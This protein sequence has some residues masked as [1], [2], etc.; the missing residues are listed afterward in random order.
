MNTRKAYEE[1]FNVMEKHSDICI[2]DIDSLKH[3]AEIH[4]FENLL[5][6]TYGLEL[7]NG[8]IRSLDWNSIGGYINIGRWGKSHERTISWPDNDKQPVDEELVQ[9][10]FSTGAYIFGDGYPI[11]LFQQFWNEIK[12]FNPDYIDSHNLAM[13]WK[14]SN[15]KD[16]FNSFNSILKKYYVLNKENFN[17]R[18]I[19]KLEE[20][21]QK[22]KEV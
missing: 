6:Y 10:C 22:L 4:M 21:I 18:K 2:F 15:A 8:S 11:V 20:Q 16:V 7:K 9:I 12:E 5:I 13:Y 14:I 19:I 3:D 17:K 1:I